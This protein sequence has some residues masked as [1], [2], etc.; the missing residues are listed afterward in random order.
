M[1]RLLVLPQIEEINENYE[2]LQ[3]AYNDSC[4]DREEIEKSNSQLQ[5][6]NNSYKLNIGKLQEELIGLQELKSTNKRLSEEIT[7]VKELLSKQ[8]YDNIALNDNIKQK[9]HS[10]DQLNKTIENNKAVYAADLQRLNKDHEKDS[11]EIKDKL[12]IEKDKSL[13]ELK[14]LHQN[15]I[16]KLQSKYNTDISKY[17]A[18][19]K[20]LLEELEKSS[21]IHKRNSSNARQVKQKNNI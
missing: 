10:I 3:S 15:E 8:Q 20:K 18:D 1:T 4:K 17:N 11:Q 14:K 16:E 7:S 6:L 5:E 19:Y 13:L 21:Q 2:L 12:E 9:E